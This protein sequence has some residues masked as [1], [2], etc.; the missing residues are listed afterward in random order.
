M[1]VWLCVC[2]REREGE[3]EIERESRGKLYLIE[4]PRIKRREKVANTLSL[5]LNKFKGFQRHRK[6]SWTSNIFRVFSKQG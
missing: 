3:K 6:F 2:E 5:S 1:C 4:I